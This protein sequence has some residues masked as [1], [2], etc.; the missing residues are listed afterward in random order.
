MEL[1]AGIDI[2]GTKTAIAIAESSGKILRKQRLDT[3]PDN[4]RA[5]LR[6]IATEVRSIAGAFP[7]ELV[8]VGVGC[9]GPLD[10]ERGLVLSPPNLPGWKHVELV[11]DLSSLLGAQVVLENDANAAAMGER[12]AGAARGFD[13]VLYVTVS[14]GIGGG[15]IVNGRLIHGVGGGA[16]EIGHMTV[17]PEGPLCACGQRGC[18]EA[19][20][21]GSGMVRRAR[22]LVAAGEPSQ[23]VDF[24]AGLT[25]RDIASAAYAGDDLAGRIWD[26]AVQYL[27][28][29]L[30]NAIV[31]LAPAV[32]V[33]G[34]GLAMTGEKLLG[35]LREEIY[36]RISIVP[37]KQIEIRAAELGG[38]SGLLGAVALA[39]DNIDCV[40]ARAVAQ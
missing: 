5:A 8:S 15:I 19:L 23:L 31:V 35:P 6:E 33:V 29:G 9:C 16:G 27:A 2:G 20:S 18:L 40:R 32:V 36:R 3:Q 13:D 17:W 4:P 22:E 11:A 24:G 10:L 34:G 21:S 37:A 12:E 26:E 39:R 28:I 25:A 30:A 38:E 7:G 1:L 14:T